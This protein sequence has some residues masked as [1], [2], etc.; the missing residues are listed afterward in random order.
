MN[1]QKNTGAKTVILSIV[2]LFCFSTTTAGPFIINSLTIDDFKIVGDYLLINNQIAIK[3]SE[4]ISIGRSLR[5]HQYG[6]EIVQKRDGVGE[7]SPLWIRAEQ[8]EGRVLEKPN[9]LLLLE[10]LDL[11]EKEK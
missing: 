11:L 10:L 4:I 7:T 2:I 1:N 5:G 9:T 8:K 6:I 3:R